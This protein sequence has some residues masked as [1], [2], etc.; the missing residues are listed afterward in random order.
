MQTV[1]I[2][3]PGKG[4]LREVVDPVVR[5]PYVKVRVLVTPMCTEYKA[6]RNGSPSHLLGHEAAGE[7]VECPQEGSV[8]LGDRVVVMPGYPCGVCG[9]CLRGEYIHCR[10]MRDP[11]ADCGSS[12]GTA[13]YA[14]YLIKPHWLCIP[15]P[16]SVSYDHASMACCGLGPTFGA[17]RRIALDGHDTVLITGMGPVGLGGVICAGR[18]GARVIAA[19]PHPYRRDLAKRLGAD[20][21]VDPTVSG[22]LGEIIGLAGGEGVDK[23]VDCTGV[24]AAQRMCID[25]ARRH[26]AVAFVGEGGEVGVAVSNDLIRKGLTLRGSWHWNLGDTHRMMGMIE[27]VGDLLDI[28]ITHTFPLSRVQEAWELQLTGECGKILLYPWEEERGTN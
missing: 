11:L 22:A 4:G 13:T 14:Q 2:S 1:E 18:L 8:R 28:Q 23:A 5:G 3:G 15:I 24:P 16:D 17:M 26:G 9:L 7:V 6:F 21:V 10:S 19:E 12:T 20:H 25:S 27:E